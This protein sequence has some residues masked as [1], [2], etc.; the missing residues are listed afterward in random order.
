MS[1]AI[2]TSP[3]KVAFYDTVGQCIRRLRTEAGVTQRKLA[4]DI[5]AS[6]TSITNI[7]AGVSMPSLWLVSLIA[8]ALDCSLDD[9][10]PVTIDAP[11]ED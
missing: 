1:R 5:G 4:A 2:G 8:H 7:E 3:A 6:T 10:A 9:I 11:A